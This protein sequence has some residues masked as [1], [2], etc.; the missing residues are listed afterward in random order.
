MS[1]AGKAWLILEKTIGEDC[2]S[3]ISILKPRHSVKF[4]RKFMEQLYVDKYATIE[5]KIAYKKDWRSWPYPVEHEV[6]YQYFLHFL[7]CGHNPFMV[8]HYCHKIKIEGNLLSYTFKILTERRE[9]L[10][11]V[12]NE[13]TRTITIS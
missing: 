13:C 3:L 6:G 11:P 2:D 12:F 9:D 7:H 1:D 4:I 10:S 8:A 5:E